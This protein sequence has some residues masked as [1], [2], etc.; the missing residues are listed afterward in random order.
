M[1]LLITFLIS[2]F[3]SFIGS[4]PPGT[5]NL[6][7]I[8]LGLSNKIKAAWRFALA[9]ALIE[10]PY[11]W[12]AVKCEKLITASPWIIDNLHLITAVVMIG[13]G[14]ITVWTPGKP[15]KLSIKF[16]DS[17]FRKGVILGILNPLALPY[18]IGVTAYLKSQRW[19]DLSTDLNRHAYLTGVS[20]GALTLLIL[21]AYLA[22]KVEAGLSHR[23]WQ[24]KIPGYILLVL[25]LYALLQYLKP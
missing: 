5:L 12:I 19:I 20:V 18:W 11:A 13:L 22:R 15:S 17:G 14:A 24:K 3:F 16:N 21:L 6:T 7:I 4:I 25:G 8:Q 1:A 23:T 10:Y 9:T 2:F